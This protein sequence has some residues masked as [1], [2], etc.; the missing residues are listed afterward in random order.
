M[1]RRPDVEARFAALGVELKGTAP[2]EFAAHIERELA[3]WARIVK[4]SGAKLD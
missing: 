2:E 4:A 1:V 3:K